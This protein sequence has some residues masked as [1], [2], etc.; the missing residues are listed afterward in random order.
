MERTQF[1]KWNKFIHLYKNFCTHTGSDRV[2]SS[3]GALQRSLT[4]CWKSQRLSG[5]QG[6][7][8]EGAD[9]GCGRCC[10]NQ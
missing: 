2:E 10:Q 9:G 1:T 6:E 3:S 4:G 7:D 5:A 8:Q